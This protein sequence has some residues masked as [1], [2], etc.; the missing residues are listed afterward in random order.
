MKKNIIIVILVLTG[1][2]SCKEDFLDIRPI[3]AVNSETYYTTQKAA[4]QAVTAIYS[5]L[6]NVAFDK[7]LIMAVDVVSDDAEAGGEYV[8]EVPSYENFNRM[9][10]L[11]T[12]GELEN[13]YGTLFAIVYFSNLALEKLPTIKQIDKKA[14]SRTIDRLMGEAKFMRALAYSYLS[15]Y[16]GGVPLV[17]HVL[18][19][20][21]Y[22]LPKAKL[23]DIYKLIEKDLKEA[24]EV[25][26]ERSQFGPNNIGRASKGAARALLARNLLFE[27]SYA[28]YYPNDERFEGMTQ[29]WSEALKYAE[30][31]IN[32]GEYFLPGI[33][34]ERYNTWRGPNTNGYRYVFTSNGDNTEGIFEIQDIVDGLGWAQA[35]GNAITQYI[36]ARRYL[37]Q[38][39]NPQ[40]TDYW[41]LDLP[42]WSLINEFEPGDPRLRSGIAWEGSGDSIEIK[43]GKRFPISYDKSVT[44]T[45]CTKYECSAAEF[46]DVNGPWHSA[47]INIKLIRYAEVL[48][49]AAEAA[50][51][52]GQNDKALQYINQV[53]KRAR[54]C[55]PVGNQVPADLTGTVTL[56]DIIH[57][58]RVELY[59]EGHRYYDL[60]RWN[61]AKQ[62]LN[63]NTHD[64][65]QVIYE[66]P[67]H[68]FLPLPQKE[69]NS[70]P[71]L[72]QYP[73]W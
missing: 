13:V 7:D 29:R 48:L 55:G 33:N 51:M 31:V 27:S 4:E 42:T 36:S 72:K 43:G 19:A 49:I 16:F 62:Y 9:V 28:R 25:L 38:N 12:Q 46:K 23:I 35:R 22:Y 14:D 17:D 70:N 40:N 71:N 3:A 20:E 65:Y 52:T 2:I 39:G 50:V 47:P 18:S 64:G 5:Q 59:Q 26:P 1:L 61:L 15:K 66:S 10:P 34:G 30:D 67:K 56:Q 58:R 69:I 44:K 41:G 68:D 11:A 21:E 24:I 57:E 63:H 32:S 54:M 53:R 60:V 37:D 45:Y 8:N 6:N 73:G